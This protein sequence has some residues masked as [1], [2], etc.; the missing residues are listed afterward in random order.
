MTVEYITPAVEAR[1]VEIQMLLEDRG[2]QRAP[3]IPNL[4][5]AA[6]TNQ[7]VERLDL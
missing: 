2:Q 6:I 7:S 1:A 5:I 3:S 4:L